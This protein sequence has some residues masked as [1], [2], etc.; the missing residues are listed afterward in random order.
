MRAR[1]KQEVKSPSQTDPLPIV[2]DQLETR[3]GGD[4]AFMSLQRTGSLALCIVVL[5]AACRVEAPD[6]ARA[7]PVSA[8]R[9]DTPD[10]APLIGAVLINRT[11]LPVEHWGKDS[12]E[13]AMGDDAPVIADDTLS[14]AVSYSGGCA[15][16]DL[17]LVA[18]R[19]FLQSDP[20]QLI[21]FLAHEANGDMCEA[22][23]TERYDF[24]LA[25]IRNLYRQAYGS[26]EGVV[27]LRLRGPE[28]FRGLP[29]LTYTF[30]DGSPGLRSD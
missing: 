11:N 7:R 23:P 18:E 3:P 24:D 25:P 28:P 5:V 21:V 19:L 17:T 12:Y 6:A 30:Q 29:D 2:D 16:H 9:G 1:L 14:L 22:Y 4:G 20:V 26:N 8:A 13:L 10:P 15:R 27:R